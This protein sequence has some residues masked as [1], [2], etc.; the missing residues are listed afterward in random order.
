MM[1]ALGARLLVDEGGSYY[2][3]ARNYR[4]KFIGQFNDALSDV[5]GLAAPSTP[6]TAQEIGEFE[7]GITPP[8]NWNMHSTN[9]TGYPSITLPC[10]ELNGLPDSLQLISTWWDDSTVLDLAYVSEQDA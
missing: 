6:T 3:R 2:I 9:L 10:S 4:G 8:V 5:D 7:R 1:P